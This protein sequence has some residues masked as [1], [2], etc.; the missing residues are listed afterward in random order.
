MGAFHIIAV[1]MKHGKS[2]LCIKI[3]AAMSVSYAAESIWTVAGK[4]RKVK[5]GRL[6]P[7]TNVAHCVR[8]DTEK[9][10]DE[11]SSFS[12]ATTEK[13]RQLRGTWFT[14]GKMASEQRTEL[15]FQESFPY[16]KIILSRGSKTATGPP[17]IAEQCRG[18]GRGSFCEKR[19]K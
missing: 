15:L 17:V 11:E 19:T 12:T 8:L 6:F 9:R 5:P 10:N 18:T 14:E 1:K 2:L 3:G 4:R 13:S 16:W 7:L